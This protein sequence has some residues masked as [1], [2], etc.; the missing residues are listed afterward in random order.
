M[1]AGA[2]I[3]FSGLPGAGKSTLAARLASKLGATYLRIDTIEQCLRDILELANVEGEGYELAHRI[4]E[5]N[6]RLAKKALG[7]VAE[8]TVRYFLYL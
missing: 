6:L 3:I 1:T 4:A 8:G 7:Q 2:L 5:E